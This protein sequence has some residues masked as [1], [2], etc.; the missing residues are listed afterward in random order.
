MGKIM[1]SPVLRVVRRFG[2]G[3]GLLLAGIGQ[4][5]AQGEIDIQW[6][7]ANRF[8]LFTQHAYFDAQV[9]AYRAVNGKSVLDTEQKLAD[10]SRGVGWAASIEH[11]CYNSRTGRVPPKCVRD[12]VEEDY[13]NPKDLRIKLMAKLP[14]SFADAKCTWTIGS[15]AAAKTV[16]DRDC[17]APVVDQRVPPNSATAVT[18]VA[19]NEAGQTVQGSSNVEPRDV[20]IVGLG[21]ST[22]SGEGNPSKPVV[23]SDTG[24]CFRRVL[25]SDRHR[26]FLPG[27][28]N[29]RVVADCPLPAEERDQRDLWEQAN[30]GWMFAPCHLS[31]Y[32]YQ[33]RAALAL[34][35]ENPHLSV[36]YYPLGCTGA[37]IEAGMLGP[38]ASRER[39]KSGNTTF[40]PTVRSQIEQLSGYLG[41]TGNNVARRP[42]LILLTVGGNDL[43]FAGLVADLLISENPE[44]DIVK[45]Q[46]LVSDVAD[47]RREFG[48]LNR[49]FKALRR[50]LLRFTGDNLERVVFVNYGNPTMHQGDKICPAGRRGFDAHPAFSVNGSKTEATARF[51]EDEFLPRLKALA[52]CSNGGDCSDAER[53]RMTYV[54][55]HRA[56]FLQHGFCAASDQDPAFDRD[57][58]RNGDSFNDGGQGGLT[59]PLKCRRSVRNFRPYTKR[60][61]WIRT[62]N[63]SYFTAMTYPSMGTLTRPSDI[64][65]GL[66]GVA[67]VVYGGAIHPTGEG[68][69][70]MADATLPAARRVLGLSEIVADLPEPMQD[71]DPEQ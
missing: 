29:A 3:T 61:R 47:S 65:D 52:T 38:Q 27:R 21:D 49:N 31:L 57:C 19:R 18:V 41:L 7:V 6:E 12:S 14:S 37:T 71:D 39:P 1:I 22:A 13:L 44:R 9:K 35:I 23:L 34:A 25:L 11:L 4:A 53:E 67:S 56:A 60:A 50:A 58:F 30:A 68:H 20:L 59:T 63:D 55:G 64:H 43:K 15:G 28:A 33:S 48:A 24:F 32:S 70:A 42:D 66:W 54:D 17:R 26:F 69:A 16:S 10:D 2:L 8:R 62:V 40:P 5:A 45:R 36:T 51:V 46:G